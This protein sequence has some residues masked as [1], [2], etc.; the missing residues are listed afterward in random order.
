MPLSV[1]RAILVGCRAWCA[2][3]PTPS[4][5]KFASDFVLE[6][7][8]RHICKTGLIHGQ[9]E[10]SRSDVRGNIVEDFEVRA[11]DMRHVGLSTAFRGL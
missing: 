7:L 10:Q 1:K 6:I 5:S 8:H 11:A 9:L 4:F 2:D 3:G